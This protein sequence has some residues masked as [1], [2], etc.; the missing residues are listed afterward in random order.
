MAI[1]TLDYS[2]DMLGLASRDHEKQIGKSYQVSLE[3]LQ[4]LIKLANI[5]HGNNLSGDCP[6]LGQG[7]LHVPM[8]LYL[9]MSLVS[10]R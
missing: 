1:C 3:T 10:H 5:L 8:V 2:E 9:T 4:E 6:C 7:C